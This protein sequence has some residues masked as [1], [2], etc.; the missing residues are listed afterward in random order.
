MSAPHKS[1]EETPEEW[2]RYAGGDLRVAQQTLT[3]E[4]PVFHLVCFLSQGAAE[5][6]IKGQLVAQGWKLQKAHDILLLLKNCQPFDKT[7]AGMIDE[8][9]ILNQYITAGRYTGDIG[10][11]SL[12]KAEAEEALAAARRIRDRVLELMFK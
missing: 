12:G 1:P 6:Y 2:F 8:G 10:V 9:A 4:E 7:L 3:D 11:A 5:K